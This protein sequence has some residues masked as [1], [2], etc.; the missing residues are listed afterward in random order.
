MS[1]V[2]ATSK[3][4]YLEVIEFLLYL[5]EVLATR[6]DTYANPTHDGFRWTCGK[7]CDVR[8][9]YFS[10]SIAYSYDTELYFVRRDLIQA[11]MDFL[12]D[13]LAKASAPAQRKKVPWIVAFGHRPMYCSNIDGDDCTTPKSIVR[14]K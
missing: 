12:D 4:M 8:F 7:T 14:A 2:V 13:D 9:I 6:N 3:Y 10:V 5:C 1:L 11:H